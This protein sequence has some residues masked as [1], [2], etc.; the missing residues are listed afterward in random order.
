MGSGLCLLN[1]VTD[2]APEARASVVICGSHGGLIAGALAARAGFQAVILNDAGIGLD[3]A[4]IAGV[5]QLD[6][7]GMA[8]A[9]VDCMSAEIGSASDMLENGVISFANSTASALGVEIGKSVKAAAELM[10]A[11]SA[12]NGKL[13]VPKEN[14]WEEQIDGTKVKLLCVDSASLITPEDAGRL[15]VTGSHGGLIGGDPKRACKAQARLVVFSDAGKGKNNAGTTRLPALEKRGV[16]AVTV[17][18]ETCQIGSAAS[19]LKTGVISYANEGATLV[20]ATPRL[21]LA[22]AIANIVSQLD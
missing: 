22:T 20:G 19:I 2:Y 6:K 8:A 9:A 16:A 17:D 7:I 1:S 3:Q 18:C 21:H 5:K 15:I 10:K 11:A 14:R 12:P 4:G 13:D